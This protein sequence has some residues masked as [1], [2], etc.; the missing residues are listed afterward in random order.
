MY[1]SRGATRWAR[2]AL[3]S[4]DA[5]IRRRFLR[6]VWGEPRLTA[7]VMTRNGGARL[8]RLLSQLSQ[9]ADE[10][11][12]GVDA[13]S[14]DDTLNVA[15]RWA[16][17]VYRFKLSG[18]TGPARELVLKYATGDWIL[19]VDDDELVEEGFG[20]VVRD[21]VSN[22]AITHA[23]FLRKWIVSLEPCRFVYAPWWYPD[24]QRRLFRNDRT[25]VHKPSKVHTGYW[26]SGQGLYETRASILH[27]E[28]V[29]FD[30]TARAKK[31]ERYQRQGS[32][33]AQDQYFFIPPDIATRDAV[34]PKIEAGTPFGLARVK[35]RIHRLPKVSSPQWG[36]E[37]LSIDTASR[38][39]PGE[40]VPATIRVRNS[41][42][43]TW[44][45]HSG[46]SPFVSLGNHLRDAERNQLQRE[47][48]RFP[49]KAPVRPGSEAVFFITYRAPET[50]GTYI[51]EWDMISQGECWFSSLGSRTLSSTL[52][53]GDPNVAK[54][55]LAH[56][57]S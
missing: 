43:L 56:A 34:L 37:I 38:A 40:H 10:I 14:V 24:W 57:G 45:P 32:N 26:V 1:R 49:V 42:G 55:A 41:G 54:P 13:S 51:F 16:D 20:G 52:S 15:Q 39:M 3:R 12:V 33:S 44:M 46:F 19:S 53:V 23:W 28:P 9:F 21:L 31:V 2:R 17:R 29:L 30:A 25:L 50:P 4:L 8:P 5:S 22:Q 47:G 36:A 18:H 7:A 48:D 27:L 6:H 11:V 35:R